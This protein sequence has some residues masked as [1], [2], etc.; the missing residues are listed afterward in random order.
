[1][2]T[3]VI[4][5]LPSGEKSNTKQVLDIFLNA[6]K[7]A[8][9]TQVFEEIDLL[10]EQIP[11]FE[12]LSIQA[13]YKRNYGGQALNEEEAELLE[14]NDVLIAQLKSADVVVIACPMHNFGYPA[15]VKAYIDAVVFNGE[16][17]AYDKKMMAG[18]KIITLFTSGGIYSPNVFNFEYPNWNSIAHLAAAVFGFM[19]FD[20][21]KTLGTSLRDESTKAQNL[22]KIS[23]E[24]TE[25]VN[26]WMR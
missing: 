8:N 16:T 20:E 24:I 9:P 19:G 23:E 2:K 4:K 18:K 26:K 25:I 22:A 3:L 15:I 10:Q 6:A 1:M 17:F 14:E 7:T 21:V 13:Y 5:Y 12:E 11:V